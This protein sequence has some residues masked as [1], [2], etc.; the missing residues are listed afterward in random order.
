MDCEEPNCNNRDYHSKLFSV[1]VPCYRKI[2]LAYQ[3]R[4]RLAKDAETL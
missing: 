3:E 2:N 4:R 1:C